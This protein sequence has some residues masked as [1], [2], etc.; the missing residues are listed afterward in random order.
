M[1]ITTLD[2][3]RLDFNKL[4]NPLGAT[5]QAHDVVSTLIQHNIK[6]Q[7]TGYQDGSWQNIIPSRGSHTL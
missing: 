4:C 3:N 6:D 2:L 7:G 1:L 5:Q